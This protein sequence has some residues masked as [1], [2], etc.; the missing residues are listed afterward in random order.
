MI[1][2]RVELPPIV[3]VVN[4]RQGL[5]FPPIPGSVVPLRTPASGLRP[6]SI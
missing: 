3:E 1:K 5:S 6:R 4:V 2:C